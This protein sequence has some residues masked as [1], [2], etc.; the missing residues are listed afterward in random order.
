MKKYLYKLGYIAC[1]LA[2]FFAVSS[3]NNLCIWKYHQ[4]E[5]PKELLDMEG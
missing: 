1:S 3:L 5:V 4:P 2:M